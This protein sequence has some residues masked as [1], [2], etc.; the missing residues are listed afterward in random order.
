MLDYD[1]KPFTVTEPF[2]LDKFYTMFSS[3]SESGSRFGGE[4]HDFW[5]CTYVRDGNLCNCVDG[6]VYNMEKGDLIF[7]KPMEFH[8][9]YVEDGKKAETFFFSFSL[10][11]CPEDFARDAVYKLNSK[12][13]KIME[14]IIGFSLEAV[15]N[16]TFTEEEIAHQK[17]EYINYEFIKPL[18]AFGK[19]I[20]DMATVTNYIEELFLDLYNTKNV[21]EEADSFLA[22][23][24]KKAVFY[25][26]NHISDKVTIADIAKY[27]C[28]SETSLKK[29]FYQIANTGVHKYFVQLKITQAIILLK[30]KVS[31]YEISQQLGFASQ[32]YFSAAFKR[33]TGLT[34]REYLQKNQ[35]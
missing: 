20:T 22:G 27:C 2:K 7:Y 13:R 6:K 18:L 8:Q 32:A 17:S 30:N 25:M 15:S 35:N 3:T 5:E 14:K 1:I 23:I 29:V 33:E 28:I 31:A 11:K 21:V 26:N 24:Y 16:V 4:S 34:P 10:E 12:Q 9:H 19:N